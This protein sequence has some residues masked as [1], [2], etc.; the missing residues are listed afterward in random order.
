MLLIRELHK[1]LAP[2]NLINYLCTFCCTVP[3]SLSAHVCDSPPLFE[4]NVIFASNKSNWNRR[5]RFVVT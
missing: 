5:D 4:L 3:V 2:S 1:I